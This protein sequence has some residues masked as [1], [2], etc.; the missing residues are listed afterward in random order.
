MGG[1]FGAMFFRQFVQGDAL[2]P[3]CGGCRRQKDSEK[4][5]YGGYP[6]DWGAGT[7]LM[8]SVLAMAGSNLFYSLGEMLRLA[9]AK[10]FYREPSRRRQCDDVLKACIGNIR[11]RSRGTYGA[12]R[13]HA[14][15]SPRTVSMSVASGW[16]D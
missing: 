13:I 8:E 15:L 7:E 5:E 9:H 4:S 14:E 2:A 3:F 1:H 6:R 12:P 16:L 11:Q 10:R